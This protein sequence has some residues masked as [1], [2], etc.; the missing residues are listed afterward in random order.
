MRKNHRKLRL[1]RETIRY[2]TSG[3][4][5]VAGGLSAICPETVSVCNSGCP[6]CPSVKCEGGTGT[7]V[8]CTGSVCSNTCATGGACTVSCAG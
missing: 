6:Q 3:L 4:D 2:L 7:G 1:N 5:R 8:I